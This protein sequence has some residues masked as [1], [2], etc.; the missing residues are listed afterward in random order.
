MFGRKSRAE[1]LREQAEREARA[2]L[3]LASIAAAISGARPILE[4]L[5]YDDELRKNIQD[6]VESVQEI[7]NEVQGERPQEILSRLWDDDK[8]RGSIESASAAAQTGSKRIRGERVRSEGGG[9]GRKI[10]LLVLLGGLAY[11]FFSPQTGEEAR[12]LLKETVGAIT[13]D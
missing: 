2:H 3:P 11:L 7:A 1:K 13:S 12:R 10:F 8:L 9:A 5:L 6:L 4:R